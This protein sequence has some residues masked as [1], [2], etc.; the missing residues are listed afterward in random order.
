MLSKFFEKDIHHTKHDILFQKLLQLD[1]LFYIMDKGTLC[2][3]KY[4]RKSNNIFQKN[5]FLR[6]ND[7][8]FDFNF[9]LNFQIFH[10]YLFEKK[11]VM[12]TGRLGLFK[13]KLQQ[14]ERHIRRP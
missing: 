8:P 2:N 13:N 9:S 6:Q 7:T 11:V 3:L 1:N 12:K 5:I 10:C 4:L 14:G